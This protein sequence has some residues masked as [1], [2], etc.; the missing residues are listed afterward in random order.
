[1]QHDIRKLCFDILK[2]IA[3]IREFTS[4]IDLDQYRNNRVVK[5]AVERDYEIIGE[6]LKRMQIRF[7]GEFAQIADGRKII[8]FRN[9]LAHA[10]DD[11]AD[12][13]VWD[14]T[15]SNLTI[16]QTEIE[17]ILNKHK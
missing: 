6:A 8:D 14:I 1:M 4:G 15:N 16:L 13:I 11:I 17:D 9:L 3:E 12:E 5:L 10:Y 2:A 7:E